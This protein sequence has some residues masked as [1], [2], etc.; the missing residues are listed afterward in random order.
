MRTR[1]DQVQAY[2]F[3]TRRIASA[4]LSGE[5][6]AVD[7]PMHRLALSLLASGMVATLLVAGFG[8]WGLVTN[9]GRELSG[10]LLVTERETHA[11]YIYLNG[12]LHPVANMTSVQLILGPEPPGRTGVSRALLRD[13][14]RGH[15]LGIVGAPETVPA[16]DDLVRLPWS[17]CS[18]PPTADLPEPS[19]TLVVGADLPHGSPLGEHSLYVAVGGTGYLIWRDRLLRLSHP[20]APVELGLAAM[21][22]T[23]IGTQLLNALTTGPDLDLPR[24]AGAGE[25]TGVEVAGHPVHV[26]E[27]FF[28]TGQHYLMT[29]EGLRPVGTLAVALHTSAGGAPVRE[30]SGIEVTNLLVSNEPVEGTAFPAEVPSVHPA[31]GQSPTICA[32]YRGGGDTEPAV[33]VEVFADPPNQFGHA[34][35]LRQ[36]ERD[37]VAAADRLWLPPG[38]GALV[39]AASTTGETTAGATVYLVTDTGHKYPIS[40]DD[41][42]IAL[43]YREVE[44]E[45]VPVDLLE[46]VPT[47]PTLDIDEARGGVAPPLA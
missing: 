44:P 32:V 3:V 8:V 28:I 29:R 31:N 21:T 13:I 20:V 18:V 17:V 30:I 19:T 15:P 47:G 35:P 4:M 7:R 5:P 45:P 46:L 24:P 34:L 36:T 10:D 6:E 23:P 43:G 11:R 40:T 26:G 12:R 22:P 1:R 25:P 9:Q 16:A 27:I 2:R 33:T 42:R 37:V 41:A 39:R 14:P 38:R